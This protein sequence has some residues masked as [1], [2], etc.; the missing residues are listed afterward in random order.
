VCLRPAIRGS[1]QIRHG[2]LISPS[3]VRSNS[4]VSQ[5]QVIHARVTS[6]GSF[7]SLVAAVLLYTLTTGALA[8]APPSS[9]PA[10]PAS[11]AEGVSE[12][13]R[14]DRFYLETSLYTRHFSSDP[15]HV[16]KQKLIL[17]EWNITE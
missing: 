11:Q 2:V 9:P 6:Y 5:S 3:F 15:A 17:G 16:D 8:Q 7:A 13:W 10:A 1:G 4:S 12:P 14:T